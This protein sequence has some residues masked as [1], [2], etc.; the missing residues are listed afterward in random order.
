[1]YSVVGCSDC[2]SFWILE[3]DQETTVCRSCGKQ[4]TTEKLKRF[5]QTPEKEEAKEARAELLA[6]KAGYGDEYREQREEFR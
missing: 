2:G 6:E 3:G 5:I 1:M 4:H